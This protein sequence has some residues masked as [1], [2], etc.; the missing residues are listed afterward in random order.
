MSWSGES[1][2]HACSARGVITNSQQQ[3]ERKIESTKCVNPEVYFNAPR[4]SIRLP[5]DVLQKSHEPTDAKK[6]ITRS[7]MRNT[8]MGTGYKREPIEVIRLLNSEG[9]FTGNYLVVDGNTTIT[10]ASEPEFGLSKV[11]AIVKEETT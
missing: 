6:E 10:V 2:R 4:G 1:Q 3:V 7:I 5:M 9:I 8:R 11:I